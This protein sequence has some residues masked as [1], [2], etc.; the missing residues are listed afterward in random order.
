MSRNSEQRAGQLFLFL[1]DMVCIHLGYVTAYWLLNGESLPSYATYIEL[2]VSAAVCVVLYLFGLYTSWQRRSFQ[3]LAGTIVVSLGTAAVC[4]SAAVSFFSVTF[5]SLPLIIVAFIG[6]MILLLS[7]RFV[8]WQGLRLLYGRKKVLIIAEDESSSLA[9]A[10]KLLSC[11]GR[12]FAIGGWLPWK[13]E[14]QLKE[15]LQATDAV[16]IS[17]SI[18]EQ[19]KRE[20]VRLCIKLEKEMLVVPQLFEITIGRSVHQQVDDTLVLSIPPFKMSRCQ[21]AVKRLFDLVAS[22]V[23]AAAAS[24][25]IIGLMVFIPLTSKGP[26]LFKQERIGRE[27]KPYQIYKFR[28]MVQHA[29][30]QTGPVMATELDPRITFLGRWIRATR[31]DELPQLYNVIKGDMSLVGPRPERKFFIDQFQQQQP[32]YSY[33]MAVKPGVTGLAQVMA[34][35]STSAEDKWRFDLMYIR[36]YSFTADIKILLQTVLVMLQRKQANGIQKN[37]H[38]KEQQLLQLLRQD[39]AAGQ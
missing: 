28:S 38:Q 26:A 6:H 21:R 15:G 31:L 12:W 20:I 39:E 9:L 3:Q 13:G 8:M 24:P 34:K 30:Q 18:N 1:V 2:G 37:N 10:D 29:E 11:S 14:R 36:H 16:L 17:P 22:L 33:R 35:Y 32:D 5:F 25:F 4:I 23:I 7:S 27:G 19:Q